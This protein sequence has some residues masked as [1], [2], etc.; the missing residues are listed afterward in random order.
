MSE[1]FARRWTLVP[2]AVLAAGLLMLG[3]AGMLLMDW[4]GDHDR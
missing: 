2:V 1:F 3:M 4:V